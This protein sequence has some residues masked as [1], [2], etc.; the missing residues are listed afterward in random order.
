[1]TTAYC[2]ACQKAQPMRVTSWWER[3]R[4]TLILVERITCAVCHRWLKDSMTKD[5]TLRR[6][7]EALRP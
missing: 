2:P 3:K 4:G 6:S 5:D 7:N 1:M